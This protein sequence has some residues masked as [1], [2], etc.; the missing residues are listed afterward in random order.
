MRRILLLTAVLI[1]TP[2][3]RGAELP[4]AD[5]DA[6]VTEAIGAFHVPGAAVAVV[7]DGRSVHVKGYGVRELGTPDAVTGETVFPIASCSK[8]F[9]SAVIAMLVHE[10]KMKWDDPIRK[11]LPWFRL[12]DPLADREVTIRDAL[13]HRVGLARHD[14]LR[15]SSPDTNEDI[16]RR[17]A[18]LPQLH[19]F[20]SRY[21]YNNLMF[22]A[23]AQAAAEVDGRPW[24]EVLR[25]RV[26]GPLGMK[27]ALA[28][29][30]A[31]A[32]AADHATPHALNAQ[33]KAEVMG[34]E[35]IRSLDGGGKVCLSARDASRWLLFQLAG[36]E[37][38]GKRLLAAAHLRETHTPQVVVRIDG[39]RQA[40]YAEDETT[41]RS[42]GLGWNVHDYRGHPVVSHT[43][44]LPA[45]VSQTILVPRSKLG[46]FVVCNRGLD[47]NG[48]CL[49][50]A[51][52]SRT[53][54]DRLLGRPRKDWNAMYVEAEKKDRDGVEKRA[55]DRA[56]ER[57]P[58]TKPSRDLAAYG[59]SYDNPAYGGVGVAVEDGVL[60]VRWSSFTLRLEHF[61]F[62]T[63]AVESG[64]LTAWGADDRVVFRLGADG[65]VIGMGFLGQEFHKAESEP[66][67]ALS[68]R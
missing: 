42:Y 59:G 6:L 43:G 20:R 44:G 37:I 8:A 15:F 36:G 53:L 47:A 3:A 23:A 55:R 66:A 54:L 68:G 33:G 28:S 67:K 62:D 61:H 50:P 35:S 11:H 41:H 63:F 60:K 13:C 27:N 16:L 40:V 45:F 64:T 14:V 57:R 24:E 38:D 2:A 18:H 30:E 17:L 49:F 58:G 65:K 51:A 56:A 22:L 46:V 9:T 39:P 5:I 32:K 1:L 19:S 10:G 7:R 26:F 48:R 21:E 29:P 25:R 52:V 12:N 4:E 31:A 34:W